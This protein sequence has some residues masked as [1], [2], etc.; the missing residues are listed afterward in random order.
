MGVSGLPDDGTG[1]WRTACGRGPV[2]VQ[3]SHVGSLS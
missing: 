1:E 3:K 2:A